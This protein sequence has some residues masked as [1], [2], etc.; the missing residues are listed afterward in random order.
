MAE[1]KG[2]PNGSKD[3]GGEDQKIMVGEKEY[4]ADDV[5]NL[6]ANVSTLTQKGES[7]QGIMDMC[8][9]YEMDPG[10]FLEQSTGALSAISNL[11]NEG[12]I[13][14]QGQVIEK[15]A[16]KKKDT[17]DGLDLDTGK[18]KIKSAP[19]ADEAVLKALEGITQ[20]V[21]GYGKKIDKLEG[22]Q[23]SMIHDQ[24]RERIQKKYPNLS[25]K[26]ADQVL[27][28][29]MNDSRK[30]LWKHAEEASTARVA[31]TE[32]IERKY[33]EDHDLDY[34]KLKAADENKLKE[35]EAK[36]GG[37]PTLKGKKIK[38][39]ATG[40]DEITPFEASTAFLRK[41]AEE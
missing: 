27:A 39:N 20:S 38:F 25:D 33:A 18:P 8:A 11:I 21:E 26:D 9:R 35:Q 36:G 2:D 37:A 22:I 12:V 14:A 17:D 29:A 24:Y 6:I 5:G 40:P 4:S 31:A 7:V 34:D 30:D 32:A 16:P 28:L 41:Q 3:K 19:K 15:G 10:E 23:T 13:D 1:Q